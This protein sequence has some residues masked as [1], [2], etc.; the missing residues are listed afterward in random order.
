MQVI[1]QEIQSVKQ[2]SIAIMAADFVLIKASGVKACVVLGM[3]MSST[4]QQSLR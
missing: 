1:E 4:A 2:Q 3:L